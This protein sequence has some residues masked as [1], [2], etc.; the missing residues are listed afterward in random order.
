MPYQEVKRAQIRP[1]PPTT[2]IDAPV[3]TSLDFVN[4][5]LRRLSMEVVDCHNRV[6]QF[7]NAVGNGLTTIAIVLPAPVADALYF[8]G[9]DFSFDNGGYWT[10]AKTTSGFTLNW[11]TA[12]VG[13]Q[14]VRILVID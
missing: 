10:S 11:A 1:A 3:S 6:E 4:E 12:S 9:A 13:A 14:S 7:D 5:G 2:G 8:V